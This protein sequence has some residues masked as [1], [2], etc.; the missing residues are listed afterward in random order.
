MSRHYSPHS[1]YTS[2]QTGRLDR[3]RADHR[4][5][6][7]H[8]GYGQSWQPGSHTDTDLGYEDYEDYEDY[9][10]DIDNR[11]KWIA[12]VS[13]ATLLVAA[14]C[15][16]VILGGGDS[17][18]VSA[19]VGRSAQTRPPVS[20]AAPHDT[21]AALPPPVASLAP[22]TI[23]TVTPT[24]LPSPSANATPDPA[25]SALAPPPPAA[26][27]TPRAITYTVTGNRQLIDFVTVIYTDQ[28]GALQTEVNV[29]LPWSK[30]VVLDPGVEL[31]SVTATS[32][33]GQLNCTI[34]DAAGAALVTQNNNSMIATCTQ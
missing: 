17:G 27:A 22:E 18:S 20:A 11:W 2:A 9:E 13:G 1:P 5:Y 24:S 28:Q 16:L 4:D 21:S 30:T 31:K 15:T 23:T 25:P 6:G 3:P 8:T 32:I 19:T 33:G 34:T 14:L 26:A 29:A 10:T 7:D 12:A